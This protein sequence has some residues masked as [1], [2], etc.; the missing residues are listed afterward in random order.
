M[1]LKDIMKR[2]RCLERKRP[3]GDEETDV[4]M[5]LIDMK[6]VSRIL[7][8]PEISQE[9]LRWCEKELTRVRIWDGKVLRDS[10]PLPFPVH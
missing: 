6:I 1:R 10:S 3:N 8:M 5:G 4:L 2:R 9:Q 7:R